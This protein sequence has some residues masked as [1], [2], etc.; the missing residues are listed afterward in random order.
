VEQQFDSWRRGIRR[1][2][3]RMFSGFC[4]TVA[5]LQLRSLLLGA[6][7]D[8]RWIGVNAA[9]IV[10]LLTVAARG[11]RGTLDGRDAVAFAV[12]L[13]VSAATPA[14][15]Q[16]PT[17]TGGDGNPAFFVLATTLLL[18]IVLLD[19]AAVPVAIVGASGLYVACSVLVGDRMLGAAVDETVLL[20]SSQVA[21]W[22]VF[23]LLAREAVRADHAHYRA[24]TEQGL[25]ARREA[26][27]E[28]TL[29]AQR[30]LHDRVLTALLLLVHTQADRLAYV[31]QECRD[32]A[33]AVSA[34]G[35][36]STSETDPLSDELLHSRIRTEAA[37][38]VET[39]G[40][41]ALVRHR[42]GPRAVSLPGPVGDAVCGA[43]AEALRNVG[44][45]AGVRSAEVLVTAGAGGGL[46]VEVVDRGRGLPP[47]SAA[48]FGLRHSVST[49]LREVGGSARID[50][51]PEGGT[52]VTL[53][54]EPDSD[55]EPAVAAGASV[56][57]GAEPEL[58]RIPTH[59]RT[60][61]IAFTATL[62]AGALY[63]A[64]RYPFASS[65]WWTD[66][67]VLAGV[68]A[69]VVCCVVAVPWP[70]ALRRL[71]HAGY[72]VLPAL[73]AAGLYLAGPGSLRSFDSWVVGLASVPVLL[74][75]MARPPRPVVALAL[76]ES[77]VVA[78]AA[79]IDP[80]VSPLDVLAPITQTPMFAGL[81]VWGVSAV[82]R[83]RRTGEL[84][85]AAA[86]A[87]LALTQA[88]G[89]RQRAIET[90]VEWLG[91]DV[92]PFLA[93]VA[94]EEL[95]P[96]DPAV[97]R[98]ASVL[99]LGVRDE[100]AIPAQL[101]AEVRRHIAVARSRGTRVHVRAS[102]EWSPDA[103]QG[104]LEKVL[105]LLAESEGVAEI[106]VSCPQKSSAGLTVVVRPALSMT[107][108]AAAE[109]LLGAKTVEIDDDD[110]VSII[111]LTS[112]DLERT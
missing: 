49:R 58:T 47:G 66:V 10:C 33:A 55:T 4:L 27:Q 15:L 87:A 13:G 5:V 83:V 75:A 111:T 91:S 90:H 59:P 110:I 23:N 7:E 85:E 28:T 45:H 82:Q 40:V 78:A 99:A 37:R 32:A 112:F 69:Y 62:L 53:G 6:D 96:T 43:V 52:R 106:T 65:S 17:S 25:A 56:S 22:L 76:L 57:V 79:V 100:L 16:D 9:A 109:A 54:W 46:L 12:L 73:L 30:V 1:V 48:G 89:A 2:S 31:R 97:H 101:S 18:Y 103:A 71:H 104:D 14:L 93:A 3:F 70:A 74:L 102:D 44:R 42:P 39:T 77:G 63:L 21:I 29:A 8:L 34:L 61:A 36:R 51:S 68:L 26:E 38:A 72:V 107:Q 105:G 11:W 50:V 81:M 64:V 92:K 67:G 84:D 24:I 95:D 98:R 20:A 108:R 86:A 88:V 80:V 19:G 60:F 41:S 35:E 94:D